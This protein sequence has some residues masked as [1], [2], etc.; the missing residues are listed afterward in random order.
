MS[1]N[2][3]Q[4][5]FVLLLSDVRRKT[6]RS[7]EFYKEV[8]K[9]AEDPDIKEAIES[10]AFVA[11]KSLDKIDQA[12]KLI[13]QKPVTLSGKTEEVFVEDFRREVA[14]I[15]TP[16]VRKIFI[17]SKLMHL[18]HWRIGEYMAL[19]AAADTTGHYGVGVL[20]ES[21]LGDYLA[22]VE[23]NRRIIRKA[24]ELKAATRATG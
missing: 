20:L 16:I 5:L 14:E 21:C 13:N 23:R 9:L 8:G 15:K 11:E 22:F 19:V 17:L 24:V 6:E 4:E 2:N 7:V 12:F 10:R 3:P 18:T 1:V